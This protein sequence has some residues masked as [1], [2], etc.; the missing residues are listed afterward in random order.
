MRSLHHLE[1]RQLCATPDGRLAGE[2]L[3]DSV[4]A[5]I[6]TARQGPTAL[7]N[8]VCKLDPSQYWMGGYNLNLTLPPA[9]WEGD[10]EIDQLIALV[11]TFFI[12]GGQE[13]QLACLDGNT[14]REARQHPDRYQD[15]IVRVSGFN[16]RFIDL[17]LLEQDELIARADSC[18]NT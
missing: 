6:G 3:A 18:V 15:L 12:H 8:S 14:L 1:G 13:L 2:P 10:E 17:P 4:G 7:L 5:Q 16:A 11:D 9:R